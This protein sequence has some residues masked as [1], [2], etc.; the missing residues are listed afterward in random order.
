LSIL[1]GNVGR[2]LGGSRNAAAVVCCSN[3]ASGRDTSGSSD[4][5]I[6]RDPSRYCASHARALAELVARAFRRFKSTGSCEYRSEVL[7]A[8]LEAD[9]RRGTIVM[10]AL[11]AK[12]R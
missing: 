5:R 7:Q 6:S 10:A 11:P 1:L 12:V 8:E 4:D 9:S 3:D 2:L